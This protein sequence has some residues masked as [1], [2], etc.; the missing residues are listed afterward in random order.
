MTKVSYL[1]FMSWIRL[2]YEVV[3]IN[4][5]NLIQHWIL[6]HIPPVGRHV[7]EMNAYLGLNNEAQKIFYGINNFN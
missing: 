6:V 5:F 2:N 1:I 4:T 3:A 7:L